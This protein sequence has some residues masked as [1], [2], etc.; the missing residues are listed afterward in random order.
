MAILK[1]AQIGHPALRT[2]AQPIADAELAGGELQ[3]LVDDLVATMREYS[4]VGLAAPQV[5]R[6]VRAFVMEVAASERYPD[7]PPLP[8]TV[9]VNPKVTPLTDEQALGWEGCLSLAGLRGKVPRY[10]AI[11]LDGVDR[12]GEA[13]A[14]ELEGFSAVV[15]QHETDHLDGIVYLDRMP[16]MSTLMAEEEYRRRELE[17]TSPEPQ[18]GPQ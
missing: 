15:A 11:R 1:V 16:D 18:G 9:V 8:L 4:G 12:R 17:P 10:T 2:P 6:S 13:L 5:R 14:L 3:R 7:R